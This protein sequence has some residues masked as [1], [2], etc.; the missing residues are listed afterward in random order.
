[1][2]AMQRTQFISK[3]DA[4]AITPTEVPGFLLTNTSFDDTTIKALEQRVTKEEFKRLMEKKRHLV[5]MI[6]SYTSEI[7]TAIGNTGP[8]L[9]PTR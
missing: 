4:L 3:M 2:T 1:M 8:S 7:N 9:Q 6:N 5:S